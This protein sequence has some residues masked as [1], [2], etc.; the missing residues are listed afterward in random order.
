MGRHKKLEEGEMVNEIVTQDERIAH[1]IKIQDMEK[2]NQELSKKDW[3]KAVY[4]IRNNKL[5]KKV[6][7]ASGNEYIHFVAKIKTKNETKSSEIKAKIEML[8][9]KGLVIEIDGVKTK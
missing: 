1:E 5:L 3:E 8:K 4:I 6:T 7:A 2:K 9:K